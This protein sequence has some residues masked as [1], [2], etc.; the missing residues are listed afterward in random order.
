MDTFVQD[1]RYSVRRLAKHPGVV[2]VAVLSLAVGIGVNTAMF[3]VLNALLL[4]PI[5]VREPDRTV[6]V[7]HSSPERPDR[8]TSFPAY[9]SYRSRTDVF[10]DAMAFTGARPLMLVDGDRREQ[11]YAEPVTASFFSL[12]EINV[13]LGR[14]FDRRSTSP[15]LRISSPSSVTRSGSGGSGRIRR[16]VG[17]TLLIN[18]RT[19][20]V[21]GVAAAGFTGLDP[22][23]SA[24][25]WIPIATWAHVMGEG[26]AD[27]RGTLVDDG[28]TLEERRDVR[29]GAGAWR[30]GSS[31]PAVRGMTSR[32]GSG[33]SSSCAPPNRWGTRYL[34]A[35]VRWRSDCSCWRSHARTS[36]TS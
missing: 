23:A 19:F 16:V 6:V 18:D 32:S 13:R 31:E 20:T 36:R 25:L 33:R 11:V 34:L 26:P 30:R 4:R 24:D 15:P 9:L 17:K 3:S 29:A 27:R 5:P 28:R 7:Y 10:A 21:T 12:T 35:S 1:L 8:G 14:S 2:V 22:E